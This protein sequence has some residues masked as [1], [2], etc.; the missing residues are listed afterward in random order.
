MTQRTSREPRT[1]ARIAVVG[2]GVA[3]LAAARRLAELGAAVTVLEKSRGPGGRAA[4]R[5]D[6]PL[7][8]DHGMQFFTARRD[9]FRRQVTECID[10]GVVGVW[11]PR[12]EGGLQPNAAAVAAGSLPGGGV[13][14]GGGGGGAPPFETDPAALGSTPE[15]WHVCVPA[16]NAPCRDLAEH[17]GIRLIPS[18]RIDRVR[19][20]ASGPRLL[21]DRHP[22]AAGRVPPPEGSL[23]DAIEREP[24]DAV[25]LTAPAPQIPAMLDGGSNGGM[26]AFLGDVKLAPCWALMLRFAE[27]PAVDWDV[28][29]RGGEDPLAWMC[30]EASKPG[31]RRDPAGGEAWIVHASPD[32]SATHLE[33]DS[34]DAARR[35]YG[36]VA[37]AFGAA[38]G[39]PESAVAHRWR[40]ALVQ[41]QATEPSWWDDACR[42]GAAGDWA[43]A[44]RFESGFLSGRHLAD[45][46]A[47]TLRLA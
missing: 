20:T 10:R 28:R 47:G 3:G 40:W 6:G 12:L 32:W 21:V 23:A 1:E 38:A 2:A 41:Q 4:T 25:L 26:T 45:R 17:P 22:A 44:G 31:R 34:E 15:P 42:V 37:D 8:F 5:H 33:L 24:W 36:L 18:L 13:T 27:P 16:N 39:P 9:P 43:V 11:S 29:R 30:R 19:K 35:L 46:V 14:G 7:R